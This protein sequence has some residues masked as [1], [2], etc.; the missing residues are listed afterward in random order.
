M[1]F[2]DCENFSLFKTQYEQFTPGLDVL[3]P[4]ILSRPKIVR[5]LW[6][7]YPTTR[8]QFTNPN[9]RATAIAAEQNSLETIVLLH[10]LG[11][12]ITV[13]AAA[14]A[15]RSQHYHLLIW[16]IFINRFPYD[17]RVHQYLATNGHATI[18]RI[19]HAVNDQIIFDAIHRGAPAHAIA[20]LYSLHKWT[21]HR[22][23]V[24]VMDLSV[25]QSEIGMRAAT[26]GNISVLEWVARQ[27]F[28]INAYTYCAALINKRFDSADWIKQHVIEPMPGLLYDAAQFD[29]LEAAHWLEKN[30]IAPEEKYYRRAFKIAV[31]NGSLAVAKW[32]HHRGVRPPL[33]PEMLAERSGS[34]AMVEWVA[35]VVPPTLSCA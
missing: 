16:L 6:T 23:K 30:L 22:S 7:F 14:E 24:S 8:L 17:S 25:L 20:N 32:L 2:L 27:R 15:A 11:C 13:D 35:D 12:P 33:H 34:Q 28:P 18:F 4:R 10:Q 3:H 1:D 29:V 26:H 31:G 21:H 19:L 5:W 9:G